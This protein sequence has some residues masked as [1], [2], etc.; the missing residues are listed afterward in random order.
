MHFVWLNP[1]TGK[2]RA[3]CH[4]FMHTTLDKMCKDV[5]WI[6]LRKDEY[7]EAMLCRRNF[8][9]ERDMEVEQ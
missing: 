5:S 9:R 1:V 6:D 2:R 8:G 4:S 3:L 7:I